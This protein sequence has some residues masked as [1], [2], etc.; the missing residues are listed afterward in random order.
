MIN[1]DKTTE[2][3]LYING[4]KHVCIRWFDKIRFEWR[5][6]TIKAEQ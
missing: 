1:Y 2:E 4:V 5:T 3:I 6:T